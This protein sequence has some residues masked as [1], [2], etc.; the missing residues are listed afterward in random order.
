MDGVLNR[1][2][3]W[4]LLRLP[5]DLLGEGGEDLLR[6][7][8]R[9]LGKEEERELLRLLP[10]ALLGEG[11]EELELLCLRRHLTSILSRGH[12]RNVN[13]IWMKQTCKNIFF[14]IPLWNS[15][16]SPQGETL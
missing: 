1:R 16:L 7:C 12:T 2:L 15:R 9:L 5:L 14:A 4:C 10:L 6:L 13:Q 8:R 3:C 11:K